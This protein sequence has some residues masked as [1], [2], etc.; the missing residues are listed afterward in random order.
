MNKIAKAFKAFGLICRHPYLLNHVLDDEQV[1]KREVLKH[2]NFPQGLPVVDLADLFPGFHQV[3]DPYAYLSG[4]TM[5]TDI[6]LL[7]SLAQK[8]GARS[9]FEIGTWRGESVANV[10]A[11]VPECV[12]LNLS[13]EEIIG[14]TGSTAYADLHGLFSRD[15]S[16]VRQIYGNSMQ[17]DFSPYAGKFDLVFIDGDHHYE[18]VRNDSA[19]VMPLLRDEHAVIVWHDYGYDPE[20]VRWSVFQGILDGLPGECHRRLVHVAHTMCAVLLPDDILKTLK[21]KPLGEFERP[22]HY[23]EVTLDAREMERK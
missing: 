16:G 13:R 3:V 18:A 7:K 14:L 15:L 11:V 22:N 12:T 21:T 5:P 19:A 2:Y 20:T 10:A 23:F 17:F 9:Y 4:A 8:I 6:A 1:R